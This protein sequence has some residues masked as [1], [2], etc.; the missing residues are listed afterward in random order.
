MRFDSSCNCRHAMHLV[1]R[2]STGGTLWLGGSRASGSADLMLA[3]GVAAVLSAASWPKPVA[4]PRIQTLGTYDG[5][6]LIAGTV[7]MLALLKAVGRVLQ[8]LGAGCGVLVCCRNGAHRSSYVV[9]IIIVYLTRLPVAEVAEYVAALRNIVQLSENHPSKHSRN[10]PPPLEHLLQIEE[11]VRGRAESDNAPVLPLNL[12]VSP[13]EFRLYALTLGFRQPG[14]GDSSASGSD[15]AFPGT[16][17]KSQCAPP[18]RRSEPGQ[19]PCRSTSKN[20]F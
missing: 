5:T 4:D 14:H 3:N 8:L 16:S 18:R 15:R 13:N 7:D 10:L 17:A 9:V 1:L 20:R 12:N 19:A 11:M 2:T 6:G